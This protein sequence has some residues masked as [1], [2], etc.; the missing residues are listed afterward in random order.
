MGKGS[1]AEKELR[2]TKRQL[3]ELEEEVEKELEEDLEKELERELG[4]DSDL[5]DSEAFRK[6]GWLIKEDDEEYRLS[7]DDDFLEHRK[8]AKRAK[9]ADESEAKEERTAAPGPYGPKIWSGGTE[10]WCGWSRRHL[11]EQPLPAMSAAG[12]A[13]ANCLKSRLLRDPKLCLHGAFIMSGCP[14]VTE[15]MGRSGYGFLVVDMEHSPAETT[16]ALPLLQ[17]ASAARCPALLRV[18]LNRP[19]LIKKALDLGPD[20][21]VVPLVDSAEDARAAIRA[22]CYPPRGIRGVAHPL[23]RASHWG[24]DPSYAEHCEE[25][26]LLLCQVESAEGVKAAGEILDVDGVDG[27]FLG[28]LDLSAS[29]G[30][31][32][33]PGHPD[34]KAAIA[35]VE[36]ACLERPGKILA[37]FA[38]GRGAKEMLQAG[39]R[40]IADTADMLLLRTAAQANVQAFEADASS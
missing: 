38:G 19:E 33:Q 30:H 5:S 11:G 24:L 9:T 15:L 39:Y 1:A 16:S 32:G 4:L 17:A 36:A 26:Q 10:V 20:G 31:F 29:M 7:Q 14:L 18:A 34:V 35:D 6:L 37:G 40:L 28:P 13:A 21:L 3:E 12:V 25:R 22:C 23:V 27:I 8:R 2:K